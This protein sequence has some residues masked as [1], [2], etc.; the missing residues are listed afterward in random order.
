MLQGTSHVAGQ[1]ASSAPAGLPPTTSVANPIIAGSPQG[2]VSRGQTPISISFG[3]GELAATM[4]ATQYRTARPLKP[5]PLLLGPEGPALVRQDP[6]LGPAP[7]VTGRTSWP[8]PTSM[9][10]ICFAW[11]RIIRWVSV[12]CAGAWV[13]RP[14]VSGPA[15]FSGGGRP[16]NW[17]Q[18]TRSRESSLRGK[19]PDVFMFGRL[20]G[21]P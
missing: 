21:Y 17:H 10:G 8:S 1:V 14:N 16:V 15:T 13:T 4:Q 3:N 6:F 12:R 11:A 9:T 2:R 18:P 20:L 7:T 5:R 19:R